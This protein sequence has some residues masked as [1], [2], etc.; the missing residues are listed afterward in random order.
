MPAR[1]GSKHHLAK[2][3]E[4]DVREA[5]RRRAAGETVESIWLSF[6]HIECMS[7]VQYMLQGK[8][9]RHVK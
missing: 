6:P 4:E 5:R 9:W 2:L 7:T 1:K 3:T 8:T